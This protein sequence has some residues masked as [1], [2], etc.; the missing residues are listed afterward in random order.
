MQTTRRRSVAAPPLGRYPQL[1]EW[2]QNGAVLHVVTTSSTTRRSTSTSTPTQHLRRCETLPQDAPSA[3]GRRFRRVESPLDARRVAVSLDRR[4]HGVWIARGMK[5]ILTC[6]DGSQRAPYVLTA[7]VSLARSTGATVRLFRAVSLPPEVPAQLYAVSPNDVP[8]IL[9]ESAREEL[10]ELARDVPPELLDGLYVHVGSPWDAICT[11]GRVHDADLIV[12]GS[13]GYGALDHVLGTTAA[14][15]VNHA[16]RSVLLVRSKG[17]GDP[18][19]EG[20]E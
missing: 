4:R 20:D 9:L 1:R 15:V 6:L 10:A 11:A 2:S 3:R 14:R 19:S 5:R 13:H 7:A 16:D 12:I 17:R 18:R 8:D